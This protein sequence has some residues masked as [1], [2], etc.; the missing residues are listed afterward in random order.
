M[1]RST[2]GALADVCFDTA[3]VQVTKRAFM[4]AFIVQTGTGSTTTGL[5]L[6]TWLN[7]TSG[8]AR[9]DEVFSSHSDTAQTAWRPARRPAVEAIPSRT[10]R[11]ADGLDFNDGSRAPLRSR[12]P[13]VAASRY[14]AGPDPADG[15]ARPLATVRICSRLACLKSAELS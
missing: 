12:A 13:T 8:T 4:P 1:K 14:V 11:K 2:A 15:H 3:T 5:Q 10:D 6:S 7:S 9:C